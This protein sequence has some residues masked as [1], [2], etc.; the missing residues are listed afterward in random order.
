MEIKGFTDK[1][2]FILKKYRYPLIVLAVG[3]VLMTIPELKRNENN[4]PEI[5][6]QEVSDVSMEDRLSYI[7]SQIKGAGSVQV[8]LTEATGEEIYYQTNGNEN[9]GENTYS[10]NTDTVIITDADRNQNGLVRQVNPPAYRGAVVVCQGADNPTIHLA[11]VDAVS[12]LT[13]LGA[14]QISVLKMK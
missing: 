14:N 7:L 4:V 1:I 9:N 10:K 6:S 8:L 13:G 2:S 12:K 11:I 3:L 5:T